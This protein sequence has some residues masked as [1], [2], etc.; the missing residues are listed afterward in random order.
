[1]I[2]DIC[3]KSTYQTTEEDDDVD[4]FVQLKTGKKKGGEAKI[5]KQEKPV[6]KLNQPLKQASA[7][8]GKKKGCAC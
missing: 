1:M 8:A 2:E 4:E 6:V 7:P 5:K 3:Y